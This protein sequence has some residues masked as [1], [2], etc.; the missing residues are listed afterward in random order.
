MSPDAQEDFRDAIHAKK[1]A[2]AAA[3]AVKIEA[4]ME[5]TESTGPVNTPPMS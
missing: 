1:G 3:A 2:D 4:L 5:K